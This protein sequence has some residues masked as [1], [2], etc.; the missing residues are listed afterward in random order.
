MLLW[1]GSKEQSP[2][3]SLLLTILCWTAPSA[4]SRAGLQDGEEPCPEESACAAMA[5]QQ[6]AKP[7]C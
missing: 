6:G 5:G 4:S 7:S 2:V 1:Q 3:A